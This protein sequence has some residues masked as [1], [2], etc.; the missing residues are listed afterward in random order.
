[1]RSSGRTTVSRTRERMPSVRRRRRGRRVRS[2]GARVES[3][4]GFQLFV[5]IRL[6]GEVVGT[7][8]VGGTE[9]PAEAGAMGAVGA[10]EAVADVA[11]LEPGLL[12]GVSTRHAGS[13]AGLRHGSPSAR[14]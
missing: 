14:N 10:E 7:A 3:V 2:A 9:P 1:M 5:V 6:S 13:F 8:A 12:L 4:V 11:L